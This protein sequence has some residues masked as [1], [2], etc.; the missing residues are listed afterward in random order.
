MLSDSVFGVKSRPCIRYF[1]IA[2]AYKTVTKSTRE[3]KACHVAQGGLD[4]V[5][6]G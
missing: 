2:S 5:T 1:F 6:E 3:G 4:L